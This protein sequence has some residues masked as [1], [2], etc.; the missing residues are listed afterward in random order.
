MRYVVFALALLYALLS[1]YAAFTQRK[2]PDR[3]LS[4]I[5]MAVGSLALI[6][7][8]IL[9][10]TGWTLDWALCIIGTLLI[11]QAAVINGKLNGRVHPKHHAVRFVITLLLIIGFSIW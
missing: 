11:V 4:A 10:L 7:A 2:R 8:S 9:C 1:L 6:A 3:R 5:L